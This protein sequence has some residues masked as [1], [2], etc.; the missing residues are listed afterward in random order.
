MS[1]RLSLAA[2]R[3][4]KL[5]AA[6]LC[7]TLFASCFEFS[8]ALAQDQVRQGDWVRDLNDAM[9]RASMTD[10]DIFIDFAGD[11]SSLPSTRLLEQVLNRPEFQTPAR[12][13]FI[14]TLIASSGEEGSDE[15]T[16]KQL[17]ELQETYQIRGF[18]TI[19]LTDSKGRPYA[20]FVGYHGESVDEFSLRVNEA[21]EYRLER[22]QLLRR[23]EL[24][25]GI[26]RSRMLHRALEPI[27]G[28]WRVR[29]YRNEMNEIISND[30]GN[31][32]GLRVP[33]ELQLIRYDSQTKEVR[34]SV[35]QLDRILESFEV[36]N[37]QQQKI[38][39]MKAALL[40]DVDR[41]FS[42]DVFVQ[43]RRLNVNSRLGI[44]I[45]RVLETAFVDAE[46]ESD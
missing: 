8:S 20:K 25:R 13:D 4:A 14:L 5:I 37:E 26:E 7:F 30:P 33:Y 9:N 40:Y 19:V 21:F 31:V 23:S 15:P 38:L 36:S 11:E 46:P 18:P 3:S 10:R 42:H 32:A 35:K 6:L 24:I 45:R 17:Q 22:D 1:R 2:F 27:Q 34:E 43:A 39:F 12:R 44:K 16:D 41:D 29:H 28:S